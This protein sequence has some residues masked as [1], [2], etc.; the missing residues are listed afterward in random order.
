M[1]GRREKMWPRQQEWENECESYLLVWEK[2]NFDFLKV[3]KPTK[4][5]LGLDF[6]G[7][8]LTVDQRTLVIKV[9]MGVK[10]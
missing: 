3:K 5:G 6:E 7:L 8:I 9:E 1:R 10:W 4:L 2:V